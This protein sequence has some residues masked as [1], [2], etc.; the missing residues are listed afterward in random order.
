MRARDREKE[1]E[2]E[3]VR[4]T[5]GVNIKTTHALNTA[6]CVYSCARAHTCVCMCVR[7]RVCMVLLYV[8][9]GHMSVYVCMCMCMCACVR[10]CDRGFVSN[11]SFQ[12]HNI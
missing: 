3:R 2:S 4:K 9:R 7:G 10:V 1:K 6:F 11:C 8:C 5:C 12:P